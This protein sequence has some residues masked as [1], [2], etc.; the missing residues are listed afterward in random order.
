MLLM[1]L[2]C[3]SLAAGVGS[4]P[5]LPWPGT[6]VSMVLISLGI[7][8][9]IPIASTVVSRL[10]PV[11]LRGR[12]MGAW[13][14]VYMA[15]YALGPLLGGWALDALGRPARVRGRRGRLPGRR[16]PVPAAARQRERQDGQGRGVGGDARA[17][18]RGERP[19]QAV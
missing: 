3:L 14:L 17:E 19:E 16:R 6:L 2:C 4:A 15:G 18:L 1:T 9:L 5:F 8:L 12:Y 10:A 11:E 13:T 7:V